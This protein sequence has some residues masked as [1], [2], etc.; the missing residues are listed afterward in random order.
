MQ[1]FETDV[2]EVAIRKLDELG[3]RCGEAGVRGR[4]VVLMICRK[5][6]ASLLL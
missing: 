1:L 3:V 4:T 6:Y 5:Y 2:I